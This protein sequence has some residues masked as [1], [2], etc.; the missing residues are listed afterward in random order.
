M[1]A[2]LEI[3]THT[4]PT[5]Q[6][7]SN[8]INTFDALTLA[9]QQG[10]TPEALTSI[11]S[12]HE[13]LQAV[14]S[15]KAF[16]AAIAAAKSELPTIKKNRT[17]DFTGK[18]NVRTHYNFEDL[19]E[20]SATITPILSS[21]GLS[22]RFR[23]NQENGLISVTCIIAHEDGYSEETTLAASGDNSGN[24]NSIQAI[25]ST[26]TYL[27][28]YTLKAALGLAVA[29]DDDGAKADEASNTPI[30]DAQRDELLSL[31]NDVGMNV[32][33]WCQFYKVDAVKELPAAQFESAKKKLKLTK[34]SRANG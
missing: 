30:T 9:I 18:T 8:V 2:A 24:K 10:A 17:V 27:Q 7:R 1:S 3:H 29:D 19:A 33:V 11:M 34:E 25:G 20:I 4:P 22:Y 12:L 16:D 28:R 6:P 14:A 26:V 15:R 23:T 31:I 21:H 13:R 32:A 5:A